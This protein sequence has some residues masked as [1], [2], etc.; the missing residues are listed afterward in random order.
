[1]NLLASA[2]VDINSEGW[3]GW[4]QNQPMYHLVELGKKIKPFVM[5][6][7]ARG[8]EV[9]EQATEKYKVYHHEKVFVNVS[10]YKFEE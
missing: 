2:M 10:I 5:D 1:M 3:K 4:N 6:I 8:V 9:I 7:K